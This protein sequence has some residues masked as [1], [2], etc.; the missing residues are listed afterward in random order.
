MAV[1]TA[2]DPR[3]TRCPRLA[4]HL[5]QVRR[6]YPEYFARPVPPFGVADP[7]LLIVGLAPGMHGAN[8]TG[9]PFTGD[10]AG[11]LLYETLHKF[12]F[13]TAP[14]SVSSDDGLE[15]I[16]CRITNAVK[17]LPP[18]NKP[19]T[20]EINTCNDFLRAELAALPENIV[21]IA[22]GTI[23]HK[24]VLRALDI[25]QSAHKFAH[26]AMH[27]LVGG[28]RLIDSYHCSRYNTQTR[29]LTP[30]MFHK[31]FRDAKKLLA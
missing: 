21:I 22:L 27:Q 23:A 18:E 8:A 14:E 4:G 29:R 11:I 15:L 16:N 2:F 7:E 19:T 24:A 6:D 28:Q 5:K 31:V 26:A 12:G 25:K 1:N 3:C 13:S 9:R 10:Y 30:A 20:Q 17:C